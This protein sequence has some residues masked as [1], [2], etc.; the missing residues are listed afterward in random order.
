MSTI[1]E[2]V[3]TCVAS[4]YLAL[5]IPPLAALLYFLQRVYLRT[6]RQL[7]VLDLEFK[8]P[9]FGHFISTTAGIMTV[10]AFSWT[11]AVEAESVRLIDASQRPHYLLFCL[12]RWLTLVLDLV[13]AGMATLLT[14][15]AVALRSSIDPGYLGV[16]LVSVMNLGQIASALI[17]HWANFETALQAVGRIQ[18]HM[19]ATPAEW[20]GRTDGGGDENP[21]ARAEPWP[22]RGEIALSDVSVF[23]GELKSLDGINLRFKA[24]SK[25]VVCGRTGSG[26]SSLLGLLLRLH[27]AA[28]GLV[29]VD[30]VDLATM[31]PGKV[32]SSIAALPQD[33][34]F[35]AGSVRD[36]L[37]PYGEHRDDD[38][39]LWA[40]LDKTG[41]KTLME[42]KGGLDSTLSVEW[43]SSGQRQLFCLARVM[44]RRSRILLLDEA[45]SQ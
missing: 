4:G 23:Y 13:T 11:A 1:A 6:S 43:L 3:L 40:V 8:A 37:D 17:M 38:S 31:S 34:L 14:G 10:R 12:Q 35:L 20:E 16:A 41:L 33:A 42:E 22:A 39:A 7:R 45:T 28:A 32:R 5:S 26:K 2:V 29:A 18:K 19:A 21:D 44:L 24:G 25:V 30:E 27:D 36:N 15:L 9:L